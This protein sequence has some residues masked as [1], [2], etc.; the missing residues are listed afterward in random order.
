MGGVGGGGGA[1]GDIGRRAVDR[2][3]DRNAKLSF[4][5]TEL[6]T[7]LCTGQTPFLSPP[8]W[9]AGACKDLAKILEQEEKRPHSSV[10]GF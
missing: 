1:G 5:S 6:C 3:V 8:A 7:A 2:S 10:L 9:L 4:L